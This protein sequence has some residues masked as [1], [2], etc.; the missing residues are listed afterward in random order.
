MLCRRRA[1]PLS[2]ESQLDS[3]V[4]IEV[5]VHEDKYCK[6]QVVE[7][8]NEDEGHHN[9]FSDGWE[10]VEANVLHGLLGRRDAT[11][12]GLDDVPHLLA[13]V[14]VKGEAMQVPE[15]VVGD[16]DVRRLLHL[17]VDKRLQLLECL[18]EE[19]K[20]PIHHEVDD[21][22]GR[23]RARPRALLQR[24]RDAVRG[25]CQEDGCDQVE[26]LGSGHTDPREDRA[27][28]VQQD[29]FRLAR[30]WPEVGLQHPQRLQECER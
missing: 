19:G 22:L 12:H 11:V 13:E 24:C 30:G 6:P 15:G 4:G 16:L 29:L 25:P 20:Q 23:H 17:D 28:P 21:N 1:E 5:Q 9:C 10:E 26:N 2:P 18:G 8:E 3:G 14:P 27:D 7:V